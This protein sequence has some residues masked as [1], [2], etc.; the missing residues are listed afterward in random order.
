M[1]IRISMRTPNK[2]TLAKLLRAIADDIEVSGNEFIDI[3]LTVIFVEN[4]KR[5]NKDP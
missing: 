4:K 3:D 1:S 5:K 2:E